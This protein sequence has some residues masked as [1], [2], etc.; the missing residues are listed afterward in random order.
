[1]LRTQDVHTVDDT[2]GGLSAR[3]VYFEICN[4]GASLEDPNSSPF[5]LRCIDVANPANCTQVNGP[6]KS[7]GGAQGAAQSLVN[8]NRINPP[9]LAWQG[10]IAQCR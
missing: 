6:Y 7:V 2:I 5:T 3:T 10:Q 4:N 1:M 8:Q 9:T